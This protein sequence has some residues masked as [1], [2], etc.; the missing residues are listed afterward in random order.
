MLVQ[1]PVKIAL[2][3]EIRAGKDTV[4]ELIEKHIKAD[5]STYFLAFADGIHKVIRK[6]FPKAYKEGKPRK[7]LQQIG[8]SF[9]VLNP[10]IWIDTLFNSNVF[11]KAARSQSNIIITDVRQPNEALRAM[12]EGF[13]VIKVTADFDVRVERAK[14]KGDSFNL[15]DFYHE[16]EMAIQQCPYDVLID[17]SY[18]LEN[19]EERVKEVL[20]EVITNEQ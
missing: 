10:D 1:K 5:K 11:N 14:A 19:L 3:G 6:Y 13:T 12:Q 15:E 7:H 4:A 2:L 8:Q 17:N 18:T 16:T 9:R 20:G